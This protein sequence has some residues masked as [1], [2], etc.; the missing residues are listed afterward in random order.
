MNI[1][2]LKASLDYMFKA[3]VTPFIWGDAGVGKSSLVRQYAAEKGFKYFPFYLGTM[4]DT[5][6]VFGVASFVKEKNGSEIATQFAPPLWISEMIQY[7]IKNPHSGAVILLDEFNRARRDLLNGM[8]S[9]ALDKTF[10]T[11]KLPS[12]C[13]IVAA[14]NPPTGD[15]SVTD[16]SDTALMGRFVHVKLEPT[17]QE[18]LEYAKTNKL[19]NTVVGFIEQQPDLLRDG[20]ESFTL[21]VK[22][23]NRS[24]E[25]WSVLKGTGIPD[26]LLDQLLLG[27]IGVERLVAYKAYLQS[28]DKP[29]TAKEVLDGTRLSTVR[30]WSSAKDIKASLISSTLDNLASLFK[31]MDTDKVVLTNEQEQDSLADFMEVIP[32][33]MSYAWF[34][35]RL[36]DGSKALSAMLRDGRHAKRYNTMVREAAGLKSVA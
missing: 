25:R 19:D 31:Q 33:D 4:S 34:S 28:A 22:V 20:K 2:D 29:L 3:Q 15:Y 7:C 24:I 23:D 12:N 8:F 10:H 1:K 18:W 36:K 17:V 13:Y 27:V 30:V 6:D 21:P 35:N 26:V 32:R 14:G 5:G 9:L 11:I 16:V